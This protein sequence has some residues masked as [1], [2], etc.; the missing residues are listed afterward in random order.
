M[1]SFIKNAIAK[2][3]TEAIASLHK[4]IKL[5]AVTPDCPKCGRS[6]CG[7][8]CSVLWP[9]GATFISDAE[10]EN[11]PLVNRHDSGAKVLDVDAVLRKSERL[12]DADNKY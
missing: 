3:E 11:R 5:H 2:A 12:P 9:S 10:K 8:V 6:T 4:S 1:N 7:P